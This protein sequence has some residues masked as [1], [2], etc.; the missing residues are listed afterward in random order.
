[1]RRL[2]LMAAL[3]AFPTLVQGQEAGQLPSEAA[4]NAVRER[5]QLALAQADRARQEENH[6]EAQR[7][8]GIAANYAQVYRSFCGGTTAE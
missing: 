4:C 7:W 8:S 6:D 1:M 2:M 3:A 5:V